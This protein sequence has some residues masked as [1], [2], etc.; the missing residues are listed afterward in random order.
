[1]IRSTSDGAAEFARH[2]EASGP[3]VD[4]HVRTA[5]REPL[6][7]AIEQYIARRQDQ[8]MA[9]VDRGADGKTGTGTGPGRPKSPIA[10]ALAGSIAS[11]VVLLALVALGV[12]LIG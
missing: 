4:G 11:I 3:P 12:H 6:E 1:V 10:S 5:N 8:E 2:A 9:L 7:H